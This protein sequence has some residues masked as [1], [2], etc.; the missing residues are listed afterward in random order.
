MPKGNSSHPGSTKPLFLLG[1]SD[2]SISEGGQKQDGDQ[3]VPGKP[4]P[5]KPETEKPGREVDKGAQR[6]KRPKKRIG[7]PSPPNKRGRSELA[8]SLRRLCRLLCFLL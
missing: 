1:M 2:G 7:M 4:K 5:G 3:T 6:V 8:L